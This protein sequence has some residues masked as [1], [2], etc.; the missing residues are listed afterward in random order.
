MM[1]LPVH[2]LC[3]VGLL[4]LS[5]QARALVC[6]SITTY[7]DRFD[8]IAYNG[9]NGSQNWAGNWSEIGDDNDPDGG[10]IK[11]KDDISKYNLKLS[12]K[13]SNPVGIQRDLDLGGFGAEAIAR[14]EFA[15]RQKDFR[16]ASDYFNIEISTDGGN[17]WQQ[18]G[19]LGGP[20]NTAIYSS[21]S[22]DISAFLSATTRLRFISST[23]Y[24]EDY[25]LYLDDITITVTDITGC[26]PLQASHYAIVH[27]GIALSCQTE[28]I[29]IRRHDELERIDSTAFT[30]TIQLSTSTGNGDWT[31]ISG[32]G[33]LQNTGHGLADYHWS[34]LDQGEVVLG[35]SNGIRETL[36]I[37]ISD[38]TLRE[39][40]SEDPDL[41]VKDP[42]IRT[43]A[44]NFDAIALTG[45][46]GSH[47]WLSDWTE[48]NDDDNPDDG[49]VRIKDDNRPY[50]LR[51]SGKSDRVIARGIGRSVDLGG[52][53]A[54][55]TAMLS[56]D[57][58]RSKII[59]SSDYITV[60]I[61][62]DAGN[63]W[64]E[65]GRIDG[66]SNEEFYRHAAFD[67]SL[68]MAADT[69]IRFLTSSHFDKDSKVYFDNLL[70]DVT[71]NINCSATTASHFRIVH[72]RQG[73]YCLAEPVTVT[74]KLRS[75]LT[76]DSY[77]GLLTLDTGTG[78]GNWS[79]L[80]GQGQ[81]SDVT[82]SDGLAQYRFTAGDSGVAS[83]LLSYASGP[84]TINIDAYDGAIR[85]DNSEGTL[86]FAASGLLLTASPV[87]NP[88]PTLIDQ[89]IPGQISATPL[90]LYLTA[91]GQD[92]GHPQCGVIETFDGPKSLQFW[93]HY[94]NP[95]SG[96][97]NVRI[98]N[99]NIATSELLASVQSVT[100][101]QGQ[102]QISVDYP[103][104]GQIHL[105][106]NETGTN[107]RGS[108]QGIVFKP[109]SLVLGN[110]VRTAD[111]GVNPAASDANGAVFI[112]AGQPF[113]VTVTARNA[114]GQVTPGFGRETPP[115]SVRLIPTLLAPAGG[116]N[117]PVTATT[118][119]SGRFSNGTA[120]GTDF[121]WPEVGIISLTAAIADGDYLASGDVSGPST[122]A[123][124][125][126]TPDH[127]TV[128]QTATARLQSQCGTFSYLDQPLPYAVAPDVTITA[129]SSSGQVT[130]NYQ[131]N[132]WKLADFSAS[133]NHQ[134]AI[135]SG[136]TLD[137]SLATHSPLGCPACA[138][139]GQSLF[140]GT[141]RYRRSQPE[142]DP[143]IGSV[144]IR[145][146]IRDSDGIAYN[147]NPFIIPAIGFDQGAELRSGRAHADNVFGTYAR[148]N[149]QLTM[150]A[151]SQYYDGIAGGWLDNI[152]DD[153]SQI[154]FSRTDNDI[155]TTLSPL[156]AAT[157]NAGKS[158]ITLTLTADPGHAGGSS[159]VDFNW[160]SWLPGPA[161]ATA[162][163]GLFRGDDRR[164]NWREF[165]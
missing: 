79:L 63:S 136:V 151:G 159:R 144:D 26:P 153:C 89:S 22:I 31:L 85:D 120:T 18:V 65:L 47:P 35:L 112:G 164:L 75:G 141:L 2:L 127:F 107:I 91:F 15:Y 25:K 143:F 76:A 124:G 55:T 33:Q 8:N 83:F 135:S 145:F 60:E 43:I 77:G 102:A 69:R 142:T 99:Q 30:G 27:D 94:D 57:Y 24:D 3:I 103:D 114:L 12:V 88:P 5:A 93:S 104:A 121:L 129:R 17:Q 118:G 6:G 80:N 95:S 165:H 158:A 126:F 21:A 113:S 86:N 38:G 67:I 49:D 48:I 138:G 157:L 163:F 119:F 59:G 64:H 39:A 1:R 34:A 97:L 155:T 100:F 14:L 32:H 73:I 109:A 29:R 19:R 53:G 98:N 45:S 37:D 154:G 110:I 42:T 116:H 13:S 41:L 96:A 78:N 82:S 137:S 23:Q 54:G 4:L 92:P 161:S 139:S 149:D 71:D 9:N 105:G 122:A 125:R 36:N 133:Y 90:T 134:G 128:T 140:G 146:N 16:S 68:Y 10:D 148:I 11:V 130:R 20:A 74:A 162:S 52:L 28:T 152:A 147:D 56:F 81:F 40:A 84:A 160:P 111:N 58:R 87:A 72:D 62:S 108:S 66:V 46:D 150:T 106:V 50:S 61:S 115:E 123:I 101:S 131:G 132:W 117:P 7:A 51:I 44:D 70:I 156:N